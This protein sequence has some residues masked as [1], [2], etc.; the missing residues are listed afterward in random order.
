M[1]RERE[2]GTERKREKDD[3]KKKKSR[4]EEEDIRIL[5]HERLVSEG[6]G[7]GEVEDG[8]DA[9]VVAHDVGA[10][11]GDEI[12][13]AGR[14]GIDEPGAERK[15]HAGGVLVRNLHHPRAF[16]AWGRGRLRADVGHVGREEPLALVIREI[17]ITVGYDAKVDSASRDA[18]LDQRQRLHDERLNGLLRPAALDRVARGDGARMHGAHHRREYGVA[19]HHDAGKGGDLGERGDRHPGANL[20]KHRTRHDVDRSERLETRRIEGDATVGEDVDEDV[21]A[22]VHHWG[23]DVDDPPRGPPAG[24]G[25]RNRYR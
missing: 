19:N 22:A 25:G 3:K 6:V 17:L 21:A 15:V 10:E 2:G 7:S 23:K 18:R 24:G 13:G 5:L 16:V 12:A 8:N 20:G 14:D 9:E 4:G 1:N 11:L